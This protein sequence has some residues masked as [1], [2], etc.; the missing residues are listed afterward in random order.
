MVCFEFSLDVLIKNK[1][2]ASIPGFDSR[3]K[4]IPQS[5]V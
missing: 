1:R 2:K 3:N 5:V 4:D